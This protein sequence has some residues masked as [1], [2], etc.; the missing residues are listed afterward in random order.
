VPGGTGGNAVS[1]PSTGDKKTNAVRQCDSVVEKSDRLTRQ[2]R[3]KKEPDAPARNNKYFLAAL[4]ALVVVV[5]CSLRI[6][7]DG[8]NGYSENRNELVRF[9]YSN[10]PLSDAGWATATSFLFL[11]AIAVL[12]I[13]LR[14]GRI[15]K[16]F[17]GADNRAST[18]GVQALMWTFL[19]AWGIVYLM[20]I[21]QR[22]GTTLVVFRDPLPYFLLLGGPWA[23]YVITAGVTQ[24][25]LDRGSLQKV[26]AAQPKISDVWS[27]DS[28]NPDVVDIQF[29]VFNLVAALYFVWALLDGTQNA[30]EGLPDL[31]LELVGLTSAAA[32]V[33]VAN[34][35]ITTNAPK[36]TG[37]SSASSEERLRP[38]SPIVVRGLNFV[39]AGSPSTQAELKGVT[40]LVLDGTEVVPTSVTDTLIE[41]EW[42]DLPLSDFKQATVAVATAANVTSNE[43]PILV[44]PNARSIEASAIDVGA[45]TTL[46]G[47]DFIEANLEASLGVTIGGSS[48]PAR[49]DGKKLEV[50]L[51]S[52]FWRTD[53]ESVEVVVTDPDTDASATCVLLIPS[54]PKIERFELSPRGGLSL[55]GS[56]SESDTVMINGVAKQPE[57]LP[58]VLTLPRSALNG[59]TGKKTVRVA[60]V[61]GRESLI[62][63]T[64]RQA[65]APRSPRASGSVEGRS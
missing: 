36:I 64:F 41:A 16:I 2:G 52:R 45:R 15:R 28:G 47:G 27:G 46:L 65:A 1:E 59:L 19:I 56:F 24:W 60:D 31:P 12:V 26:D 30:S 4:V 62:E 48:Y 8:D 53:D 9:F 61:V 51:S 55:Y 43:F 58:G 10:G 3:G 34:K 29:M 38:G 32:F 7:F 11:G 25:K 44:Y 54:A 33:F 49:I 37:V 5:A 6:Y 42:P 35:S 17:V 57:H 22:F 40:R 63:V 18:S 20:L 23:N 50:T 21:G 39:P 14:F 13:L